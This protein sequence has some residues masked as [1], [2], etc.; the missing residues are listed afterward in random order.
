M[1]ELGLVFKKHAV[2]STCS[3]MMPVLSALHPLSPACQSLS[4]L[5]SLLCLRALVGRMA[6]HPHPIRRMF[7]GIS[8]YPE[9][10]WVCLPLLN[11]DHISV[12]L[13]KV[14]MVPFSISTS[15][16]FLHFIKRRDNNAYIIA[17]TYLHCSIYST[18]KMQNV[19]SFLLFKVFFYSCG[20][21]LEL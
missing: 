12:C 5:C 15:G 18:H 7:R 17:M 14:S 2:E 4:R 1:E 13:S 9:L 20:A 8:Q 19:I 16:L 21:V 11:F 10:Y 6:L 3:A